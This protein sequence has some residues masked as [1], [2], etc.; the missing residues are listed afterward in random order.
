MLP[1]PL[2]NTHNNIILHILHFMSNYEDVFF[3]TWNTFHKICQKS[4][5]QGRQWTERGKVKVIVSNPARQCRQILPQD[6]GRQQH[7]PDPDRQGL[8]KTYPNLCFLEEAGIKEEFWNLYLHRHGYQILEE[9]SIS[10][11]SSKLFWF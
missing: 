6:P 1:N 11:Y 7:Q 5:S 8:W 3:D 9:I 4:E 10:S 2:A